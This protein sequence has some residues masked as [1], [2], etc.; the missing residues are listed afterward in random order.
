LRSRLNQLNTICF[1]LLASRLFA[2]GT[3]PR[4]YRVDDNVYRGKQPKKDDIPKLAAVGIRTV[5]DLRER[6][7]RKPW[8]KGLC[9]GIRR[10]PHF[11]LL[12]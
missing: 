2:Q 7:E 11:R 8:E 9:A 1:V 4:V 6:L 10:D 12:S 3:D 5:L